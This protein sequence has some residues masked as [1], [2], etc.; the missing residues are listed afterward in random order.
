MSFLK[1]TAIQHL[2]AS[3]PAINLTSDGKVGVGNTSPAF[4]LDVN[5]AIGTESTVFFRRPGYNTWYATNYLGSYYLNNGADR[6][7]VD[8]SGRVTKPYQPAFW[9]EGFAWSSSIQRP[10]NG[11]VRLNVGNHYNNSN[12]YFTAPIAGQYMFVCTV[13]GHNP[14]ETAGRNA[15]YFNLKVNINGS[16]IGNEIVATAA[17]ISGKHDQITYPVVVYLAANDVFYFNSN[18]GFRA[19]QNSYMGYLLG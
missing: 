19:V 8:S 11:T 17:D 15:T 2:N 4:A 6:L 5:G 7:I 9:V 13:Q 12:G 18:Y 3:T 14:G 1:T 16:D 10:A